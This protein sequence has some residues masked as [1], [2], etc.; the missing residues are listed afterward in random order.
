LMTAR[1]GRYKEEFSVPF[2]RPRSLKLKSLPEFARL[3]YRIWESLKDEVKK[4]LEET[5]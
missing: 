4:H 3:S 5:I 1:P 2:E